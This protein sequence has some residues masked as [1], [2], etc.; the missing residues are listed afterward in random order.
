M[1]LEQCKTHESFYLFY[2]WYYNRISSI[3][4]SFIAPRFS[5]ILV[6]ALL[7]YMH[8]QMCVHTENIHTLIYTHHIYICMHI[9]THIN[10][11]YIY[12]HRYMYMYIY[13]HIYTCVCIL[14]YMCMYVYIHNC[15]IHIICVC[16]CLETHGTCFQSLTFDIE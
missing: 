16:V 10:H 13:T 8:T 7:K 15:N 6:F 3:L 9:C 4:H 12:V 2:S 11:I 14:K 1:V 5:H